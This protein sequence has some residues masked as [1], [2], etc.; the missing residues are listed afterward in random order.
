[1]IYSEFRTGHRSEWWSS[2]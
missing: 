1:M 2:A